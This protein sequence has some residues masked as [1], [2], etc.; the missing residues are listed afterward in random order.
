MTVG[1]ARVARSG[2]RLVPGK[3]L[4]DDRGES[5]RG[6]LFEGD[7][8]DDAKG[9]EIPW[10]IF[11]R[12]RFAA[13]ALAALVAGW[14]ANT[15][16]AQ[17]KGTGGDATALRVYFADVEGGQAT[18]F[19]TPQG[20][21]MLVDTGWPGENG[22]DADRIAALVKRA[23]LS[24]IDDLVITHYHI[25]HAGGL[26]QLLAKVPV[27]L[28]IDHGENREFDDPDTVATW[29]AYQ[30]IVAEKGI[31]RLTVKPG[32]IVPVKGM[33]VQVVSSD[34]NLITQALGIPGSGDFENAACAASP[35]KPIENNENDRS[36]GLAISFG[37]LRVLD[38]GDLT[39]G[40]ERKL[41]C[42]LNLLGRYDVYVVSH[43]GLE[44]SSSPAL[45]QAIQPRVAV[46]DNGPRKGADAATFDT[47]AGSKTLKD[48]W[49]LHTAEANDA[50]H[51]AP[52]AHTANLAGTTDAGNWLELIGNSDSSFAIENGRTGQRVEYPPQP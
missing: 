51:N 48:V 25:D 3:L 45:V 47:L 42:P 9:S 34:G 20:G 36:V 37:L 26:T 12:F 17:A 24:R 5:R 4:V 32:D 10:R 46:I 16:L 23:G 35:E 11:M 1:N 44:R 7:V 33:L 6:V 19:V 13:V 50:K 29:K 15:L 31:K 40:M 2:M 8:C 52:E 49:E 22:R 18:L 28:L 21:S 41:V 39:W 30:K 43:H 14:S 27:G 38:L